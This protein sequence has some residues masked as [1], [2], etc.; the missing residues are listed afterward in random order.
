MAVRV[1]EIMNPEVLTLR[2]DDTV[3]HARRELLATG[4]SGAPVVDSD[5]RPLGVVSLRDLMQERE[6][7]TVRESMNAPALTID[8]RSP[9]LEAARLFAE[10]GYHR[11]V[12]VDAKG[13]T[14]GILTPSDVLRGMLGLPSLRPPT[15]PHVDAETDQVWTDVLPFHL[16]HVEAAPNHPGVFVLIHGGAGRAERIV[17]VEATTDV[18]NRLLAILDGALPKSLELLRLAGEL[19]F[20]AARIDNVETRARVLTTLRGGATSHD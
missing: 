16:D 5:K 13:F 2:P 9:I 20:R 3:K 11:L 4:V 10:T 19:R 14:V 12:A 8:A 18:R 17:W 1:E 15:F 6:V 7:L